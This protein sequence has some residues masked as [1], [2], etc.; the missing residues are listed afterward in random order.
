MIL[1]RR[2]LKVYYF[3]FV[4]KYHWFQSKMN[5][6]Q[7]MSWKNKAQFQG[8]YILIDKKMCL[9]I[10]LNVALFMI[11]SLFLFREILWQT[12][13]SKV[14]NQH[15]KIIR[16]WKKF[17][18]FYLYLNYKRIFLKVLTNYRKAFRDI[19]LHYYL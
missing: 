10:S 4:H 7:W 2:L 5:L 6:S 14:I 1:I 13:T 18:F 19:K 16:T 15:F 11:F 17:Y 3:I 12:L 8:R 9:I